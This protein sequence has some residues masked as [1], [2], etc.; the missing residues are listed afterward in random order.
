[1]RC[2]RT[3]YYDLR[4]EKLSRNVSRARLK[5]Y[6]H[7]IA[8]LKLLCAATARENTWN[9]KIYLAS[10]DTTRAQMIL[11][12]LYAYAERARAL[13]GV[14]SYRSRWREQKKKIEENVTK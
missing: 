6:V 5:V 3:S 11:P 12:K 2:T 13:R 10:R 14:K 8:A 9:V 1:M 4:A 7:A